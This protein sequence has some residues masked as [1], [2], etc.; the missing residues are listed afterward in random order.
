[1]D[2]L[3]GDI[4]R[5]PIRVF[6]EQESIKV[7]NVNTLD[8]NSK[9]KDGYVRVIAGRYRGYDRPA[10]TFTLINMWEAISMLNIEKEYQF[11]I[12]KGYT[13]LIFVKKGGVIIEGH[14]LEMADVAIMN[15]Q[16][17]CIVLKP[18]QVE[19]CILILSG[20]PIDAPIAARG[21]VV[22]NNQQELI[23]AMQD[24]HLGQNGFSHF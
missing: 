19:T 17:T 12:V 6:G 8:V 1:M 14:T 18:T 16:G 5:V 13:T 10:K 7:I 21:S 2:A 9:V 22:M 4:P 3:D 24:Y 20:E 11:D 23:D 15:R